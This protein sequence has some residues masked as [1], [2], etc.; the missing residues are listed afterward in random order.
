LTL[1]GQLRQ[2]YVALDHPLSCPHCS[3]PGKQTSPSPLLVRSAGNAWKRR[4][5]QRPADACRLYYK[6]GMPFPL[7][8]IPRIATHV[9][10]LGDIVMGK[11]T[12][13]SLVGRVP[14]TVLPRAG[15]GD[16]A[17][18][19]S[20]Q[21]HEQGPTCE[22]TPRWRVSGL[23]GRRDGQGRG[24]PPIKHGGRVQS[25]SPHRALATGAHMVE[26]SRRLARGRTTLRSWGEHRRFRCETTVLPVAAQLVA[27]R[28]VSAP[29]V[30]YN[31]PATA[32]KGQ[33][34]CPIPTER[35]RPSAR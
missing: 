27:R 32:G 26:R 2:R 15:L 17:S 6:R 12:P 25:L 14:D 34:H 5:W 8:I 22:S 20:V 23:V 9:K 4:F 16:V 11:T 3:C 35:R 31:S 19:L 33:G 28:L 21:G 29:P 1:A 10:Y 24:M 13:R 18:S 30:W 7:V